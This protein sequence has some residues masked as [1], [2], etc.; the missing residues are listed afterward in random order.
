[1]TLTLLFD[2]DNTL[3]NNGMEDFLPAYMGSLGK[4][5]SHLAEPQ[6]VTKQLLVGVQAMV[7]AN[8]PGPTLK[9]RFD[10]VFYPGIEIDYET[11]QAPL[12]DYYQNIHP[13][14]RSVTSPRPEAAELIQ[15]TLKR[16]YTVAIAT[17]PMFPRA[18]TLQR[19]SWA[20]LPAEASDF[21]VVSTYEDFHFIKPNSAYYAEVLGQIGWPSG[22]VVMVGDDPER[23]IA[24]AQGLCLPTFWVDPKGE[25][26]GNCEALISGQGKLEEFLPWLD[27][28]SE[29]DLTPSYNQPSA[30]VAILNSTPGAL[31]TLTRDLTA[32]QWR[33]RPVEDEWSLVEIVAHL[34]DSE[35]EV[36]L[37]RL[38]LLLAE[39]EPSI[40][41]LDTD[42]WAEER[43]YIAEDGPQA[44][45]AFTE[46]RS[47]SM[48]ILAELDEVGWQKLG[49]HSYFGPTTLQEL[50]RFTGRHDRLHVQQVHKTIDKIRD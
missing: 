17:N 27:S 1:M 48:D 14:V 43:N 7:A 2:L 4:H 41:G 29:E 20:E 33:Q 11:A 25:G 15:E 26:P 13:Q 40:I 21:A 6:E 10:A 34:R 3:L 49:R 47:Q 42:I 8:R 38:Q 24:G 50:V 5:I 22:P 18:G 31:E 19:L 37:P 23:D 35:I 30:L 39:D 36:N 45:A 46:A 12:E 44:L 16:G 32:E 9:E 28:L